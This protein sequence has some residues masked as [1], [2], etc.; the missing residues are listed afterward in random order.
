MKKKR[1][2]W[3]MAGAGSVLALAVL[4][5]FLVHSPGIQAQDKR[6]DHDSRIR[7]GLTI[8]PVPLKAGKDRALVGLGSYLVN[9]VTTCNA[10]HS[11]GPATEYAAGGNPYLLPPVYSG[12]KQVNPA[13]YLGGG[14]DLGEFP[15]P[16]FARIVSRNLTPDKDGLPAGHT[17]QEFLT[18]MRTGKD[19]DNAHPNC[20]SGPN[21]HCLPVPFNGNLLQIMPWPTF[22]SMTDR[23]LLAI[24]TYLTAIPCIE[25]DPGVPAPGPLKSRCR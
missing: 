6:N 16:G 1:F 12:K 21:G 25:G 17:F 23:D 8:A 3:Q 10:C 22:Q 18:I 2:P 9:A 15:A 13:T 20:T 7:Q 24:Y 5:A 19:F 14:F 11:A 4:G